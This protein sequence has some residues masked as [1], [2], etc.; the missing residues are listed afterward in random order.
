MSVVA[1]ISTKGGAGKSTVAVHLAVAA[2]MKR[3]KP[4]IVDFDKKQLSVL[5]W[6]KGLRKRAK[7]PAIVKGDF[8]SFTEDLDKARAKHDLIIIDVAAGGGDEVRDLATIA[9]HIIVPVRASAF[10]MAAT[11]NTIDLLRNSADNTEPEEIA[12]RNSL[13]KAAIVL[14][15][16]PPRRTKKWENE[17]NEALL[18]CGAGG[19]DIIGTLS[20]R[21]AFRTAIEHGHGVTEDKDDEI[22]VAEIQDLYAGLR[23]LESKREKKLKQMRRRR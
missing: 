8:E 23:A 18:S 17:V 6:G 1:I 2:A 12:Y 22:A 5:I 3:R 16:T 11:R 15:C 4:L 10:D 14:N 13:G 19:L 9:D 20:D 7:K 21:D